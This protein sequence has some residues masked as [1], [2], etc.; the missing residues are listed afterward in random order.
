L[1]TL[2]SIPVEVVESEVGIVAPE[3]VISGV[4]FAVVWSSAVHLNDLVTIVPAGAD[5]G[6]YA[7]YVRVHDNG[8]DQLVAPAEPGLYEVRYRSEERRRG[9]ES[10][11]LKVEEDYS[12]QS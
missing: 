1:R 8:Q 12:G 7:T 10:T 11:T 6:S 5:E 3:Q 9:S 2:V 4:S